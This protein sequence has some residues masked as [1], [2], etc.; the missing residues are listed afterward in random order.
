MH[1]GGFGGGW[2]HH[3]GGG[4]GGGCHPAPFYGRHWGFHPGWG[5]GYGPGIGLGALA[6]GAVLGST[7]LSP[8]PTTVYVPQQQPV[9][10]PVPQPQ[11][12]PVPQSPQPQQPQQQQQQQ[13]QQ[14]PY[15]QSMPVR[16]PPLFHANA[17]CL[18]DFVATHESEMT[19]KKGEVLE[20]ITQSPTGWTFVKNSA[21]ATGWCPDTYLEI[22]K[23]QQ[24]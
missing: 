24:Q 10:V 1:H 22:I 8:P 17:K 19:I 12:V 15:Y 23:D 18:K 13:Q 16:P 21:G 9:Y 20:I 6:A 2:G 11:Y 7:L 3:G 5:W 14:Q 4:W